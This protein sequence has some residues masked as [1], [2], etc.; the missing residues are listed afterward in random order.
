MIEAA[1]EWQLRLHSGT[2]SAKERADYAAWKLRDPEHRRAAQYAEML[3]QE[4]GHA[5]VAASVR[6]ARPKRQP[7]KALAACVAVVTVA[8]LLWFGAPGTWPDHRTG[9]GQLQTVQLDD[10][11]TLEIDADSAVTVAFTAEQRRISVRSGQIHVTVAPDAQRPFEV[12]AGGGV[13][14]AL[15]TA[16]NVRHDGDVVEVAV[17][18]HSVRVRVPPQPDAGIEVHSGQALTYRADG[19]VDAPIAADVQT[20]TAWRRGYLAFD[21]E[22]LAA[23]VERLSRHRHGLVLIRGDAIKRL[24]LTGVFRASDTDALLDALPQIMPVR[25]QR[26][27]GLTLIEPAA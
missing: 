21:G 5:G 12:E 27:P 24:P 11:S 6:A 2:A 22:P 23:V 10:G 13:T 8:A 16:F 3:W 26:W 19:G 1:L 17:T 14:R 15:G 4:I 9:I 20:L 25:V 18:E 7:L